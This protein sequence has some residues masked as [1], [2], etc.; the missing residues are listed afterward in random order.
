[1]LANTLSIVTISLALTSFV[2]AKPIGCG[3]SIKNLVVFGDSYSDVNNVYTLSNHTW[4]LA[5][6]DHGR[7]SNGPIWSEQVAHAKNLKL[8]TF[9]FGGSTSDSSLVQGYTGPTSSIPVPG[10]LQ[11]IETLYIPTIR[12]KDISKTL[13]VVNFQGN[14]FFFDPTLDP[15]AV[16]GKLHEG[17]K[18]LVS[19]GAENILLVENMN[20]GVIP[21]FNSNPTQANLFTS[22]AIQEQADYKNLVKEIVGEYGPTDPKHPFRCHY[23]K[24]SKVNV[25][26]LNLWTLFETLYKPSQLKRLGITDV[27]NGCVSNDY[28][29][30]CKDAGKHFFWDAFHPTTKIHKEIAKAVI[31]LL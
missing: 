4:P 16:V 23:K 15:K 18:R 24:A 22:I 3:S 7:F 17:I 13:F 21:Y 6:Y 5:S 29:T 2:I 14:D 12:K 28:T 25:G 30:V 31:H 8:M 10:F 1:M 9:A 11:Q 27:I 19:L 26:Y 20:M